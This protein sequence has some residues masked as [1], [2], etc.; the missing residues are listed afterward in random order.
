M[1]RGATKP[2][3]ASEVE[4]VRRRGGGG[5]AGKTEIHSA[6][7]SRPPSWP[8]SLSRI[9]VGNN[10]SGEKWASGRDHPSPRLR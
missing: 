3:A 8:L 1:C 9:R 7:R 5:G 4:A 6:E 10:G 2:V